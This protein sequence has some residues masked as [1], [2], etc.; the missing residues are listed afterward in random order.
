M[1]GVPPPTRERQRAQRRER[2]LARLKGSLPVALA[3]RFIE[4]D[5]LTHAASL[6][7]YALLSLAPLLVLLLWLTASLYGS[8]QE[9]IVDQV[10]ELAGREAASVADTVIAN[11]DQRPGIGS[12]AGLW[13]T[14]L[15]FVGATAVFA[16]LQDALNLIFR[17]DAARLPGLRAWIRKRV[18]SFGVVLALGFLLLVATTVS[19]V[20]QLILAGMPSLLPVFGSLAS[21]ALYALSFALLYHFLPDRRVRWRQALFGGLITAGLFVLGRWAIGIY[22]ASAAPGSA[23]GSMG[24]MV[25]L[26]VWM[27]YAAVV[28]FGGA[29]IT[30][31]IDERARARRIAQANAAPPAAPPG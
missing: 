22:L 4:L 25:L 28:F 29:L 7:F 13:S 31:V 19:T 3:R 30:A 26:L 17:T 2:R 5:I 10:G 27:Y 6:A 1:S 14:L 12:I 24:A 20:L 16:R 21:L 8:A 9:A 23:Y 15:L 11:A 18:L